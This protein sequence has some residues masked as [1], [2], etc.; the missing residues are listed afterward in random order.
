ME[1]PAEVIISDLELNV[2][3]NGRKTVLITNAGYSEYLPDRF[4]NNR[5]RDKYFLLYDGTGRYRVEKL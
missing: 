1:Q 2:Y 4:Y 3:K 5:M